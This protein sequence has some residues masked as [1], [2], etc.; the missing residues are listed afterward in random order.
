MH[1]IARFDCFDTIVRWSNSITFL[2]FILS[3]LYRHK[4]MSLHWYIGY[5]IYHIKNT[6]HARWNHSFWLNPVIYR[7]SIF[8][9]NSRPKLNMNINIEIKFALRGLHE[10]PYNRDYIELV[11]TVRRALFKYTMYFEALPG[12]LI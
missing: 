11:R 8:I 10:L 1:E 5:I 2:G 6:P 4:Y 7:M 12:R 9:K 3:V